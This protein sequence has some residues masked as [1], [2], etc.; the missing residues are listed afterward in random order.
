M[1]NL[2]LLIYTRAQSFNTFANCPCMKMNAVC[3]YYYN[4]RMSVLMQ[5]HAHV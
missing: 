1:Q 3:T 4:T 2:L 5:L